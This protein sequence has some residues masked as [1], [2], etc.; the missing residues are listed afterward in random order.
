[1][2]QLRAWLLRLGGLFQKKRSDREFSAEVESHLQLHIEDN[3]GAGMS[4][5]E[6]RRNAL[7]KLGGVEQTKVLLRERRGLPMAE[8][9][10]QDTRSALRTLRSNPGFTTLVVL[11]LALG[12]GANT[13][14]FTVVNAVLLRP[15]PYPERD[16]LV[17]VW[18]RSPKSPQVHNVIA[19]ADFLDWRA[20]NH[21]FDQM[22]AIGWGVGTLT[23]Q[24]EPESLVG[25]QVS[26][27]F[28][29]MLGAQ[30]ALGRTFTEEDD[31][32]GSDHVV[33]ISDRL[34]K[35]HFG[36]DPAVL[37]RPITLDGR[38][39]TI[40]GVM[41]RDFRFLSEGG[42][43]WIP[44]ALDP[45]VD[46]RARGRSMRAIAKLR[47]GVTLKQA[48]KEMDGIAARLSQQYPAFNKDWGITLVG[49][50]EQMTGNVRPALLVLLAA[51]GFVLLIAC[52][53]V[54]NLALTRATLRRREMAIRAALGAGS[55]RLSALLLTESLLLALLGGAA[56][57]ALA[58]GGVD[59]LLALGPQNIP[60]LQ[61]VHVDS[62]ALGFT[63]LLSLLTGILFGLAPAWHARR[64]D[65]NDTLKE[66]GT[67]T[68]AGGHHLRSAFVVAQVALSFVLLMGAG[69]VVRSFLRLEGTPTGFNPQNLLTL[70]VDLPASRYP[71]HQ[72]EIAFFSDALQ[73]I[74]ALPGV[75]SA[76][77][78]AFLPFSDML[79]GTDF[80]IVG[81]PAP[82]PGDAP[83]TNVV[84]A[85][86]AYFSTMRI[87][88]RRGRLFAERDTAEAPRVFVVNETFARR[89]FPNDD[90][91]GRRL[92]VAMG[93]TVPGEIVG[94]VGDIK[95]TAL[96]EG[97]QPTVYFTY[98]HLP[99][100]FMTLVVRSAWP[101][102]QLAP[103]TSVIRSID[104]DLPVAEV[105]TM[106]E[107]ISESTAQPRF[108]SLLL[109][110]FSCV[111]LLLAA[112]GLYGV[113]AFAVAQRTREIGIR[114][115][116]GAS[117]AAILHSVVG[118]G[119]GLMLSGLGSG[120]AL[121]F[122]L[123]RFLASFLFGVTPTDPATFAGV[124]TLLAV[125]AL[126]ACY[127]PARRATRVDPL[128]A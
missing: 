47:S 106:E 90:P 101:H 94:V 54:A 27:P 103:V 102:H 75:E 69:L 81:R 42:D 20:Q 46:Y 83:I 14:I 92:V 37:G 89:Y 118:Q 98:S 117:P 17:M 109:A 126:L 50:H 120:F 40:V 15:L 34:W 44:V 74:A 10:V 3:L 5:A 60:R 85:M 73:K 28:F 9:V 82:A 21:V 112:V 11:T 93:D 33:V 38:P 67:K 123:T 36:G 99:I 59:L 108:N 57:V 16:R 12:I 128:V 51:V 64:I 18:E 88:L 1:M 13:A 41:P 65:L 84:I 125:V 52:A 79:A 91:L 29:G 80:T 58:V 45:A 77:S 68:E 105:A 114:M 2:S 104:P 97:E 110:L 19:P 86:P 62:I 7:I 6:A 122:G 66:G 43:Y 119:L 8:I 56:G 4:A 116:L 55:G 35:R 53:N 30:P 124:A 32:P 48:Q 49:L 22:S 111:A 87:P 31:R 95:Q 23:G 25:R 26:A 127:V 115:A 100:G 24:G 71:K 70:R 96:Q 39:F 61:S 72:Q 121:A 107:L 78:V 113:L 76:A 63:L